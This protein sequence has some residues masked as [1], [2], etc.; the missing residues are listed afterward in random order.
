M[1]KSHWESDRQWSWSFDI[2]PAIV[3]HCQHAENQLKGGEKLYYKALSPAHTAQLQEMNML[4]KKKAWRQEL[5]LTP[6]KPSHHLVDARGP[7]RCTPFHDCAGH[8]RSEHLGQDVASAAQDADLGADQQ[9]QSHGWVQVRS[10]DVAQTLCQSGDGQREGQ[11]DLYL[12]GDLLFG[13]VF[14]GDGR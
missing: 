13:L 14:S 11:R 9:A 5:R 10:A 4:K 3:R 8:H 7:A 12:Q 1:P 6:R 2:T